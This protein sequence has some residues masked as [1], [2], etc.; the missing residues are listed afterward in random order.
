MLP[1]HSTMKIATAL[2]ALLTASNVMA[3]WPQFGRDPAHTGT[4]PVTGQPFRVVLAQIVM[5]PFASSGGGS[6]LTHYGVP[7]IDGANVYVEIKSGTFTGNWQTLTWN[8]QAFRWNGPALQAR[9]ISS[10]DWKPVPQ[11]MGG[12][13]PLLEPLFQPIMANGSIYMP[14]FGGSILRVD[15]GSGQI[16]E[17]LGIPAPLDPDTYVTGPLVADASGNVYYNAIAFQPGQ[18][19]LSDVRDAWLVRVSPAGQ[20]T[21][22][23][24]TTMTTAA[25]APTALCLGAFS[26]SELPWP[27]SR[28]AIP[29][30][31]PC[32]SQ[33][34]GIN[35]GPAI[36]GDG[37][38][39][40]VSRAH[41]N[42][43]WAYI[44][45]INP[46]LSPKW[47][48]SLRDR[49]NDGC[50]VLLPPSGTPG[51][52]KQGAMTGVD[53]SDNTVGA[54]RVIDD[55]SSSPAVAPDGSVIYGAYTRY[56][57]MQGHL[58][59]FDSAGVFLDAYRFGWDITPAIYPHDG[60]YSIVTKENHYDEA[61][62]YCDY[63]AICPPGVRR[64]DDPEGYFLTQLSPALVQEW[65][66]RNPNDVEW[67]INGPAIDVNGTIYVNAEDGYLYSFDRSGAMR[68]SIL[69]LASGGQA[70]T[71]MALDDAGRI[72]AQKGGRLFVVGTV[73]RRRAVK[74]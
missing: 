24:Y 47:S 43:R 51:G 70:Y 29:P 59:H 35:V 17:R 41:F 55:S 32:G 15:P 26:N 19:W 63:P 4:A 33:R 62:S 45:A 37:T 74:R 66:A 48:A 13:G 60:S 10:S 6:L 8:V 14:G 44:V 56:N 38:I 12:N 57:Y 50:D 65:M 52:C 30:S 49:F 69:L 54:G 61:G 7:I 21:M 16:L 22:V 46:D 42:S 39:Y 3:A 20:A 40:T 11:G 25:P 2:L 5:D 53:P 9:W 34:P 71:P 68:E 72:Y 27:P 73:G 64:S 28:T 31:I 58:M 23:R 36:A 18:P 67:C 1:Y